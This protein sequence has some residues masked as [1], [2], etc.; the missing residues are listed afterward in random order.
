[1]MVKRTFPILLLSAM[2][3]FAFTSLASQ[4]QTALP[5]TDSWRTQTG[6][7]FNFGVQPGTLFTPLHH[8]GV[9]QFVGLPI[10]PN[11]ADTL[12]ARLTDADINGNPIPIQLLSLSWQSVGLVDVDGVRYSVTA[13]L[14]PAQ[15]ADDVGTMSIM[16]S[17]L[18]GTYSAQLDAYLQVVFTPQQNPDSFEVFVPLRLNN[19]N[20][21]WV[22]KPSHIPNEVYFDPS[23]TVYNIDDGMGQVILDPVPTP[24][25]GTLVLFS[26]AA[27]A[28]FGRMK[29][30]RR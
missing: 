13:T 6:S 20:G 23:V 15:L 2:L 11:G 18:G 4:L 30:G 24:E 27:L 29:A 9:V 16:G 10:Y 14:D 19:P 21:T 26:A 25:P 8:I 17:Q 12:I 3:L 7:Y 5:G 22:G 1:M 28:A